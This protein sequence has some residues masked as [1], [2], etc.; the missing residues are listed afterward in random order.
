MEISM[1]SRSQD[2]G[3][4]IEVALDYGK[5]SKVSKPLTLEMM[6]YNTN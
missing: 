2:F 3:N 4:N 6:C 5:Q 1:E